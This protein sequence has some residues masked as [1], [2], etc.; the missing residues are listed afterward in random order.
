MILGGKRGSTLL[1]ETYLYTVKSNT[2]RRGPNIPNTAKTA[3]VIYL[4]QF[5][6]QLDVKIY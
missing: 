1:T 4:K 2:W 3:T 5:F 6:L